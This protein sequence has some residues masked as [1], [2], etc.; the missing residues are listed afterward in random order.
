MKGQQLPMVVVL[1]LVICSYQV[2][3]DHKFEQCMKDG[4]KGIKIVPGK[5]LVLAAERL[6]KERP[7]VVGMKLA[8]L[9]SEVGLIG[10]K[11]MERRHLEDLEADCDQFTRNM[12]L[13]INA[14]KCTEA[15][16]S[17][18]D[19]FDTFKASLSADLSAQMATCILLIYEY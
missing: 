11:T 10:S 3:A 18:V 8:D 19:M 1:L 5:R 13:Q 6:L 14:F 15:G 2:W 9:S 17:Y 4:F 12:S 7:Q 16:E